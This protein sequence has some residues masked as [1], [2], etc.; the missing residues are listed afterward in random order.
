MS[1][2]FFCTTLS[3]FPFNSQ[4]L[5]ATF[6]LQ[7]RLKSHRL[8]WAISKQLSAFYRQERRSQPAFSRKCSKRQTNSA[9]GVTW[10][11][12][13]LKIANS[14]DCNGTEPSGFKKHASRPIFLM[15]FKQS[16]LR[17]LIWKQ[18][19]ISQ[20]ILLSTFP[21]FLRSMGDGLQCISSAVQNQN[22]DIKR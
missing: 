10:M 17:F 9:F 20:E 6:V 7:S 3:Q 16:L 5:Y 13:G 12:T 11:I 2:L 22:V 19:C 1:R 18:S 8:F 4:H 15:G 14:V 21:V